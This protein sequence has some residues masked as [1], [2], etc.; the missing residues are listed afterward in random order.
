MVVESKSVDGVHVLKFQTFLGF[1][2][3]WSDPQGAILTKSSFK[4]CSRNCYS[5]STNFAQYLAVRGSQQS[6]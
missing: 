5:I 6:V 2:D 4:K 3:E 1:L